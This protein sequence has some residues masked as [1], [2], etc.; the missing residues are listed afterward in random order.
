MNFEIDKAVE[1]LERTPAVVRAMLGG[2]SDEWLSGGSEESWAP[3]DI[4]GHLIHAEM[5]DW[6][7]RAK[8]ILKQGENRTF[9][10]FDR[11]AQ[12][13]LSKG[14]S[15]A[16]LLDEFER[17]RQKS[18]DELRSMNLTRDQLTLKGIHPEFGEV[19]LS[20]LIAAWVA[21]DMTHIRQIAQFLAKK[22][23]NEVGPWKE[24]L[25]ILQ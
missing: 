10:P 6:I 3:F 22:Y 13:E 5:T 18:L 17:E 4:V 7:P 11:F 15:L 12:F 23:T 8:I 2:L 24:F 1:M 25:S 9:V 14:K 19:A 16:G 20:E 21:H